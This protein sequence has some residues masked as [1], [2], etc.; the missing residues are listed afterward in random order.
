MVYITLQKN[1]G[2]TGQYRRKVATQPCGLP[3][4]EIAL[5]F[6]GC[7]IHCWLCF[8]KGYSWPESFINHYRVVNNIPLTNLIEEY[9]NIPI[10]QRGYYNWLRIL[11]GEPLLSDEYINYL[12]DFLNEI[13]RNDSSK[14][15]NGVIIQTNGIHIGRGHTEV[16]NNRLNELY[17]I[18]PNVVVAI[19][20]S[21]KGTNPEEFQLLSG[22]S[23][24]LYQYNIDS[25]YKLLELNTRNLRPVVIAGFGIN[26]S[27]LTKNKNTQFKISVYNQSGFLTF[28]PSVW[29]DSF[30]NLYNDFTTKYNNEL[31]PL[32]IKMPMYGIKDD[33]QF[34]LTCLHDARRNNYFD[35]K[36]YD[37][38]DANPRNIE[39]ENQFDDIYD[40]F[41]YTNDQQYY[42]LLIE[43]LR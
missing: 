20:T 19:E 12:F 39:L 1:L 31:N 32:F 17:E 27:Y 34:A 24:D 28:H 7:N 43:P 15:N 2:E 13:S 23:T 30:R 37:K 6:G 4:K 38:A 26:E 21:I 33:A 10:P 40:K 5:R 29:D 11:G 3:P 35:G 25:Y 42:S 14:F 36:L 16:L 41:F 8:A 18:N 22:A 9:N